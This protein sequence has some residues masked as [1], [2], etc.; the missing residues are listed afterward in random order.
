MRVLLRAKG[1]QGEL[2]WFYFVDFTLVIM[3]LELREEVGAGVRNLEFLIQ[4]IVYLWSG[5]AC[6]EFKTGDKNSQISNCFAVTRF[7]G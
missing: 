2:G 4:V 3:D 1:V 5:E 6:S 7:G